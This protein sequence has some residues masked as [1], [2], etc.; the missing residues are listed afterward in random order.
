MNDKSKIVEGFSLGDIGRAFDSIGNLF[1]QIGDAFNQIANIQK[2]IECPINL[3][4]NLPTC[5]YYYSIDTFVIILYYIIYWILYIFL[6]I[7][8]FIAFTLVRITF[9][10]ISSIGL[11]FIYEN[12][13]WGKYEFLNQLN[14]TPEDI[15]STSLK[16]DISYCLEYIYRITTGD[17]NIIN[18]TSS[19]IDNCYC[20]KIQSVFDPLTDFN[21]FDITNP[22]TEYKEIYLIF[23]FFILA[24]LYM[25]QYA[26]FGI[27]T[28]FYE[29]SEE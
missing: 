15:C 28:P 29:E 7:P 16:Y 14:I 8:I 4:K 5:V 10:S 12:S 26:N 24:F 11:G 2:M 27:K 13:L 9:L 18:R 6:Y 22:S 19:D 23:S 1:N 20:N 25:C 17:I 21:N 3:M